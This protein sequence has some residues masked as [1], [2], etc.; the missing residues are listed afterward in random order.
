LT[1]RTKRRKINTSS[2]HK[3][4]LAKLDL[5]LHNSEL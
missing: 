4:G 2:F 5:N 3:T 1:N